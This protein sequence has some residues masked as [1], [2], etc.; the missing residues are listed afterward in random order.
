MGR[1][2]MRADAPVIVRLSEVGRLYK[3]SPKGTSKRGY[4]GGDDYASEYIRFEPSERFKTEP[5]TEPGFENLFDQLKERWEVLI[6][7][8]AVKVRFPFSSIEEN[9]PWENKVIKKWGN[10]EKTVTR[11]NGISCSM[12]IEDSIVDGKTRPTI[13]RGNRPCAAKEG[14][15]EC[16][17][18]CSPKG[19]LKLVIPELYPAGVVIFPLGSP[20]DISSVLG[21]LKPFEAYDLSGIPFNL[22]RKGETVSWTDPKRGEQSK[23]NFGVCLEIDPAIASGLLDSR[24]R[25]FNRLLEADFIEADVSEPQRSITPAASK[26][27]QAPQFPRSDDGM[28]FSREIVVCV[29]NL[30]EDALRSAVED[31]IELVSSGYYDESGIRWIESEYDRALRLI[32]QNSIAPVKPAPANTT[33]KTPQY[34]RICWFQNELGTSL[35]EIKTIVAEKKLPPSSKMDD[36]QAQSLIVGMLHLHYVLNRQIPIDV[37]DRSIE[38][39]L[40]NASNDEQFLNELALSIEAWQN[41][42]ENN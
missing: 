38:K 5:P 16:P 40:N 36:S 21:S 14:D 39:S 30:D 33:K 17:L 2:I 4:A 3:G 26:A 10:S 32:Q 25:Q 28:A 15:R 18:G 23:I 9:F 11:C 35:D 24:A 12:W 29:Q 34:D 41:E 31:A 42:N 37:F 13:K 27:L 8:G 22:Y 7:R 1:A 20:I 6:A 19:M